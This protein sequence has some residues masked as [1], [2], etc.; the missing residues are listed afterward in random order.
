[1]IVVGI[2]ILPLLAGCAERAKPA[3]KACGS[4]IRLDPAPEP[5]GSS[6]ALTAEFT[7]AGNMEQPISFG[8]VTRA[9]GW[10]DQWDTMI[11]VSSAM[12][13][14]WLNKMAETSPDTCW[15]GLPPR[16]GSDPASFGY[17][18][19]LNERQVVQSVRWFTGHRVLDFRAGE[20]LTHD[21][22][23]IAKSGGLRTY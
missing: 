1:M 10:S 13:D 18:V 3:G 16:S 6:K 5:L 12:D 17:Y 14:D 9:A 11:N 2:V 8:E 22:A 15:K 4:E 19:F 20:R 23:L 21:T 7:T